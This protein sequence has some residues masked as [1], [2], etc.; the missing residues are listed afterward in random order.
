MDY[1]IIREF[2]GENS[3]GQKI[4]KYLIKCQICGHEKEITKYNYDIADLNHN[5]INCKED[6]LNWWIGQQIDDYTVINRE[7]DLYTIKCNVCGVTERVNLRTLQISNYHNHFHGENCYKLL[8][9]SDI[10]EIIANRF[11]DM[12]QRCNNENNNNYNHYG[13]RGI[14]LKYKYP[15]DL[16]LDFHKNFE[17]LKQQGLDIKKYSFDRINVNGDY[18]KSNLRLTTQSIQSTNT[19][20]KKIFIVEKNNEKIICDNAMEF[21]RQY[22]INGRSLGNVIRGTSKTAGGWRLVKILSPNDD[23][24]EIIKNEGVTTKL[25][26]CE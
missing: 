6:Y 20:R 2:Y 8:P 9:T 3:Q 13:G 22:N 25:I 15:I 14:K 21:G 5:R 11:Y 26:T 17:E 1:K 23:I 18:E 4:K 19:T 12:Y 16:Y 7:N 10:K 24:E